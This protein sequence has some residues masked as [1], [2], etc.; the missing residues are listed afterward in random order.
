MIKPTSILVCSRK[1]SRRTRKNRGI[2]IRKINKIKNKW[3]KR[4][5]SFLP[6]STIYSLLITMTQVLRQSSIKRFNKFK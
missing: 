4:K 3:K 2:K 6:E 1:R 5:R